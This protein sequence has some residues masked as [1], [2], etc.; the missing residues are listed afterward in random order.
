MFVLIIGAKQGQVRLMWEDNH[1]FISDMSHRLDTAR[2]RYVRRKEKDIIFGNGE[3]GPWVDVEADEVD[4]AKVICME[5]DGTKKMHWQQ[6]A[7]VVQRGVPSSLVLYKTKSKA[8]ALRSPGPGPIRR[9]DWHPFATQ[10]LRG[11]CVFLHSDG[12]RSY[13]I[14]VNRKRYLD[15]VIHDYVVHKKKKVLGKWQKGRF[16][17]LFRH[18]LPG[19]KVVATKGGTQIIDRVWQTLRKGLKDKK[20]S[21]GQAVWDNRLRSVQWEYWNSNKDLFQATCDMVREMETPQA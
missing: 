5:G 17:Q 18:R 19:G 12:A 2:S 14:G 10:R 15:G 9:V 20:A 7:G 11:R 13:K 4:L 8:T 16:A 1:K 21:Q 6:W 3:G